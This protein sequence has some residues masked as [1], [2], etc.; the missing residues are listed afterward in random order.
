MAD[1][2]RQRD[3]NDKI[4]DNNYNMGS[5]EFEQFGPVQILT[6]FELEQLS[7]YYEAHEYYRTDQ[8]INLISE[9]WNETTWEEQFGQIK[10]IP[11]QHLSEIFTHFVTNLADQT[12]SNCE[13]FVGI[14]DFLDVNYKTLYDMIPPVYKIEI[15]K[16]IDEKYKILDKNE[17]VSS[18]SLF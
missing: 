18:V 9:L 15:L 8:L 3:R 2:K 14:A 4:F 10:K 6:A 13:M 12:Y 7:P 16:E 11:K 5:T 1:F 17:F